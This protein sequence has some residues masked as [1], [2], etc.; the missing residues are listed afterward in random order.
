MVDKQVAQYRVLESLGRGGMG[1]VYRAVDEHL[2]REV[3]L[4]VLDTSRGGSDERFRVEAVAAARLNHPGIASV[5]ELFQHDDQWIMSMEFVRGETLADLIG[6]IGALPVQQAASLC[7]QALDALSHAH[8]LGVVHRDLTPANLMISDSGV[9]KIL[10]FGIAR[11]ADTV[12]LTQDGSAVGT[13][14]YMAPEQVLG[15]EVDARADLYA[16]GVVFYRLITAKLPFE[17]TTSFTMSQAHVHE[18]PTPVECVRTDAPQWVSDVITRALEKVP[19]A[20]YQTAEEFRAAL[21][22]GMGIKPAAADERRAERTE[23]IQ[24][25]AP[26]LR[27]SRVP[28][29]SGLTPAPPSRSSV[30]IVAA[31]MILVGSLTYPVWMSSPASTIQSPMNSPA[32]ISGPPTELPGLK[33]AVST[34]HNSTGSTPV[35]PP[36]PATLPTTTPL[37]SAAKSTERPKTA[38]PTPTPRAT[39]ATAASFN[40]PA[41]LLRVQNGRAQ[42]VDV[43]VRLSDAD[44]EVLPRTGG[45]PISTMRYASIV[46][47]YV[48]AD[49]PQWRSELAWPATK[50]NVPGILGRAGH[51]LVMQTRD[52]YAILRL[53][54]KDSKTMLA[55]FE[56]RSKKS[57]SRPQDA[58]APSK[59]DQRAGLKK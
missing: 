45:A 4:K 17:A 51:W 38:A 59:S 21:A 18:I 25:L 7:I 34:A 13:P 26:G 5:Y 30:P 40:V 41:K 24:L 43:T 35:A 16:I 42:Y 57:V 48:H 10:D 55:A 20:R 52:S 33:S 15:L 50:I 12:H 23:E 28:L 54:D 56:S 2:Q 49:N 1:A 44:V 9:L 22:D 32:V 47:T 8:A 36:V 31:L 14:A 29:A 39:A 3:A 37:A 58:A 46:T 53:A 11:L 19:D 6:R 27:A